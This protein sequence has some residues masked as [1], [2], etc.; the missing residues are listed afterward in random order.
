MQKTVMKDPFYE[1]IYD[2]IKDVAPKWISPEVSTHIWTLPFPADLAP[3]VHRIVVKTID[4]FENE[5]QAARVFE[6]E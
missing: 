5:Y 6:I 3:G 4:Q 2:Q 1:R